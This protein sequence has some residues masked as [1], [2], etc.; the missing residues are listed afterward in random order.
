M[1]PSTSTGLILI[2]SALGLAR[3]QA[4]DKSQPALQAE[5]QWVHLIDAG[6]YTAAWDS[7]AKLM[8]NALPEQQF[9]NA[10]SGARTPLG[11]LRTRTLKQS[12]TATQLPG[13]P[14][15]QYVVTQYSTQFADKA[16]ATETVV[17]S[18]APDG[19]WHVAGYF[20][21]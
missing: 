4:P 20:I 6:N 16:E 5:M 17:A 21:R 3:A 7:A 8:Q 13:A 11:A 19:S 1:R 15:G 2:C 9:A 12:K 10:M 14:D 18:Q